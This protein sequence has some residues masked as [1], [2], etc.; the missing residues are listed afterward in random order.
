MRSGEP[1]ELY[2]NIHPRYMIILEKSRQ[3]P[4]YCA[5]KTPSGVFF[6]CTGNDFFAYFSQQPHVILVVIIRG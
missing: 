1:H 2:G 6:F 5:K 4:A 3:N